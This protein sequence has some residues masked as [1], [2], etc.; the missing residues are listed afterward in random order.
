[1]KKVCVILGAGASK[2][3]WNEGGPPRNMNWEPPLAAELFR[4]G[5]RPAFLGPAGPYH[6]EQVLASELGALGTA[7][8]DAK[9]LE[10]A[11]HPH[12]RMKRYFRQVPLYLRDLFL[13]VSANFTQGGASPGNLTRLL[14]RLLNSNHHVAFLDLNYDD[15]LE[16]T[17][18]FVDNQFAINGLLEYIE[19]SRAAIVGK[20]HGS[21]NWGIPIAREA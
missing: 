3:G 16:K 15:Y 17:L 6:G 1:M 19:P 5:Q 10:Y 12:E 20:V 8:L 9:L 4:F 21:I 18:A 11:K 14:L 13:S 7:P 2:D